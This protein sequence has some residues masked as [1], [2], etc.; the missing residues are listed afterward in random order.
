ME[1]L[2]KVITL[3][4]AL[5]QVFSDDNQ[6]LSDAT[7]LPYNTIASWRFNYRHQQMSYEKQ[8]EILTRLGYVFIEQS[9]WKKQVK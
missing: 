2:R 3:E 8:I 4:D 1:T 6:T 9:K 7:G 5:E